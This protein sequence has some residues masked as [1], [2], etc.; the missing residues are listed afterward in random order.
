VCPE[1]RGAG[2][3]PSPTDAIHASV[4][5]PPR[6]QGSSVVAF[7]G[8]ARAK[9]ATSI[10]AIMAAIA[11]SFFVL[12]TDHGAEVIA[13]VRCSPSWVTAD[14]ATYHAC[15]DFEREQIIENR[16]RRQTR[17]DE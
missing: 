17:F 7:I 2:R 14:Q 1:C 4:A 11:V 16:A 10:V 13:A 3:H 9:T 8:D 6:V 15:Y 12:R 5:T